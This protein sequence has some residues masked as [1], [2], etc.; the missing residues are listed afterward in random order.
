MEKRRTRNYATVVYPDSAPAD[1][2]LKLQEQCVPALISPLHDKDI[3]ADGTLKK[4]HYH[5]MIL[6]DG[7]KTSEQAQEVFSVIGG[8]GIEPIKCARAYARYLCHLDNP[9]KAQY[10]IED[11]ISCSGA[12]YYTMINLATDK[13]SAIG[14]MI[15]FCLQKGVVSYAQLLLYAKEE[16]QDW[17]RVLCDNGTL[18]MVQFLKS[19]YWEISKYEK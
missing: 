11:V 14:E 19:H 5:V 8:V 10:N 3:N 7:V 18:T 15:E 13:Y 4:E 9:E 16:R 1:W 12:D 6:F 2:I 17:F